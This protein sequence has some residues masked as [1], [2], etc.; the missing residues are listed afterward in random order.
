[1]IINYNFTFS[2]IFKLYVELSC[3]GQSTSGIRR[4]LRLVHKIEE[5]KEKSVKLTKNN[6][7]ASEL[8]TDQKQKLRELAVN[9]IIQ[10]GRSFNDLNKPG[11]VKLFNSLL[12]GML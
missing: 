9:A 2:K 4:H 3:K 6:N 7:A 5:F 1:M 10:D 8:S 11:I 12:E